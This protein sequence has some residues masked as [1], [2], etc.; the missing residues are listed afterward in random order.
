M[1][2]H[3]TFLK[4]QTNTSLKHGHVSEASSANTLGT[5]GRD[6]M[7]KK[8]ALQKWVRHE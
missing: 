3:V 1:V 4:L 8:I 5:D 2:E 7:T 6:R